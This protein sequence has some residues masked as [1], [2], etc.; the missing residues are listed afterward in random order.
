MMCMK[1]LCRLMIVCTAYFTYI[2]AS[3][4]DQTYYIAK[5]IEA[6]QA[7]DFLLGKS[8]CFKKYTLTYKY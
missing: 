6:M 1:D 4:Y 5:Q 3:I 7:C 2:H 8:I